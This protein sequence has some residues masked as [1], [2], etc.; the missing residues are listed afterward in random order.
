MNGL[1]RLRLI[2]KETT[3]GKHALTMVQD[4]QSM[5][6]KSLITGVS[7]EEDAGNP[8]DILLS[9]GTIFLSPSSTE[10]VV[11]ILSFNIRDQIATTNGHSQRF[12]QKLKSDTLEVYE[13]YYLSS[14]NPFKTS[15][16]QILLFFTKFSNNLLNFYFK[17]IA[18][19]FS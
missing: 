12:T 5:I 2:E 4:S 11:P 13:T 16:N 7:T 6:S 1:Q 3:H 19:C 9:D 14:L 18:L 15:K 10:V 8:L 17:Q